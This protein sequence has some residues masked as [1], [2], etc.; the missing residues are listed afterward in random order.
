MALF[1]LL[2]LPTEAKMTYV[3]K[4]CRDSLFHLLSS[5]LFA[6]LNSLLKEG[7][8]AWLFHANESRESLLNK[9]K[10]YAWKHEEKSDESISED[11]S[12]L[13]TP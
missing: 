2:K 9:W 4:H 10:S 5:Y 11:V 3:T 8:I 12:F 7:F 13:F 6:Q 1:K